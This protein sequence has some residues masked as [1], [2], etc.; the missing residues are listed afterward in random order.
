MTTPMRIKL[1]RPYVGDEELEAIR[2]VLVSGVLTNGPATR[3]FEAAFR[4]RHQVEHAIAFANGTVALAA[5]YLGL[6]IGPGDEVIV[7]SM[8]FIS[9]ATSVLHV[10]ATPVFADVLPDTF[11]LDPEDVRRRLTPRTRAI[12]AVHYGGQPADMAELSDIA[13]DAGVVMLEDA[14]EAHGASYRGQPVGGLGKAAMFSFT[15][16]KNITTGEG[17]IV[18]TNDGDLAA[19]LRLLRNHGQTSLYQH[20]VLG[21]NWRMT[22]MQAAMGVV[23]LGR[24]DNI[25]RR[26]RKNAT[27]FGDRLR[28]IRGVTPP[29]AQPDREHVYMLFTT[30]LDNG[31]DEVRDAMLRAGVEVRLYFPPAHRQPIF[32]GRRVDLPVTEDLSRRMLSLPFHTRLTDRQF[33]DIATTL[34]KAV[35][36]VGTHESVPRT[37]L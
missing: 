37:G 3:E 35:A 32:A 18:T 21:F 15:P 34:E 19:R 16:T 17:G 23:Q 7:P 26:K 25:I 4:Q 9:S 8:T 28:Q 14:A 11:N 1:A 5:M 20:A 13:L 12:L 31:R 24:L 36:G 27:T 2:R 6:D 33:E 29:A 10:G 30:L 22:E